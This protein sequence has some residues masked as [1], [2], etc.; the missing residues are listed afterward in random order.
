MDMEK[1]RNFNMTYLQKGGIDPFI[2]IMLSYSID[3]NWSECQEF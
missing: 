3:Q 2:H 1:S